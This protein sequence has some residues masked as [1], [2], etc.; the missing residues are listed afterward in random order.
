MT[1]KSTEFERE[2]RYLVVKWKDMNKYLTKE[3]Y[4]QLSRLAVKVHE[5]RTEDG[6]RGLNCVVVEDDWTEYETVWKMIEDRM[7]NDREE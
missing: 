6:K 1:E 5:G 2:W 3:E 7:T 4:H